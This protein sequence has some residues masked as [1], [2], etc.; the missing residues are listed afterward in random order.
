ML[1]LFA[2]PFS[3]NEPSVPPGEERRPDEV[4]LWLQ[5]HTALCL[6]IADAGSLGPEAQE[7]LKARLAA[8]AA[9]GKQI[10]SELLVQ[11]GEAS[12]SAAQPASQNLVP[13]AGSARGRI[14][15]PLSG[16]IRRLDEQ[17]PGAHPRSMRANVT[18]S[19][20]GQAPLALG[21]FPSRTYIKKAG[22]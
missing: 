15:I 16:G 22:N 11:K 6:A 4:A 5:E 7:T 10:V 1:R 9:H 12:P 8:S 21:L 14:A 19:A 3:Q 20:H 17:A 18:T 13:V 2:V